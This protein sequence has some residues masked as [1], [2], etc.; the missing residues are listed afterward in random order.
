M[1]VEIKTFI[2]NLLNELVQNVFNKSSKFKEETKLIEEEEEDDFF[3][4]SAIDRRR[5]TKNNTK[6]DSGI[7]FSSHE[8][9]KSHTRFGDNFKIRVFLFKTKNYF[10]INLFINETIYDLKNKVLDR[11]QKDHSFN[12]KYKITYLKPDGNYLLYQL[13]KYE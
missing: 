10:D 3:D 9:K 4:Y 13:L 8:K 5:L 12:D 6:K 11:L 7:D 1:S 2:R